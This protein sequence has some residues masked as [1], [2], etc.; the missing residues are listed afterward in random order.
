MASDAKKRQKK[1]E[2]RAAKRKDKKQQ[3]SRAQHLGLAERLTD[4]ARFPIL[5]CWITHS[6][7]T[8]GIGWVI[9]SRELPSRQVAVVSFL[10]DRYCLGVKDVFAEMLPRS[11]YD[12]KYLRKMHTDMPARS[13]APAEARKFVEEAVAYARG[14]GLHPHA[15]YS[16]AMLLFGSVN[17][18]ESDAVFEFGKD[19]K[20]FFVSGPN[21][22]PARCRQILATLD[23]TCGP[24]GHHYL[25]G[26]DPHELDGAPLLESSD[27]EEEL[28][29]EEDEDS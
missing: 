18:A 28:T 19:G 29:D 6:V 16:R 11:D 3:L 8:Q 1:L 9:L 20:P 27:E 2:R 22:T 10:V 23:S 13:V 24:D 15:D 12:H 7:E 17:P 26:V 25:F 14:L 5:N 4:A 21:D